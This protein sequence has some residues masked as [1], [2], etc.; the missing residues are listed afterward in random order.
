MI[1][2]VLADLDATLE[3][4]L[5]KELPAAIVAG[6]AIS[7]EAPDAG[8]TAG[9]VALPAI[10]LFLYDVRENAA[11]RSNQWALEKPANGAPLR[12]PPATRV[13]CS[14]LVTAWASGD[15]P[16][17]AQ[18]EHRL[19]AEVLKVLVRVPLVPDNLLVGELQGQQPPLPIVR[20]SPEPLQ[21]PAELWQ[22]LGGKPKAALSLTVTAGVPSGAP[23]EAGPLVK[24]R[25]VELHQ[26]TAR[27]DA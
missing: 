7:F 15:G 25:V 17:P 13:D 19:L 18:D 26:G 8:F 6:T 3:A 16:S 12:R 27:E 11:L 22:A 1:V 23:Q 21:N 4:L 24:E 10:D 14:Y 20:L 2:L 9:G 5:K